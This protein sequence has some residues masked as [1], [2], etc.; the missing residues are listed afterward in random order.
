M[1]QK[2]AFLENVV[3]VWGARTLAD[4]PEV[5]ICRA[6]CQPGNH[7][8]KTCAGTDMMSSCPGLKEDDALLSST[9]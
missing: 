4:S 7:D 2:I 1:S 5:P 3:I 8:P 9:L 6:G